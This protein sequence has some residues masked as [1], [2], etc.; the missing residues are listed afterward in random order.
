MHADV[1]WSAEAFK[2]GRQTLQNAQI[3]IHLHFMEALRSAPQ[4]HNTNQKTRNA[5]TLLFF[6]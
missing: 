2:T 1:E 5:T 3:Q 4:K 6:K